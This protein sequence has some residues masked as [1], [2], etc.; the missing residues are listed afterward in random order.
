M[1]WRVS[2]QTGKPQDKPNFL[3][4]L[5]PLTPSDL[6]LLQ[7]QLLLVLLGWFSYI[8]GQKGVVWANGHL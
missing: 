1:L 4:F 6:L 5:R 7:P 8:A 2:P 3:L